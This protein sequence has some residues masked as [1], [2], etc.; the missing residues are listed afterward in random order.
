[1]RRRRTIGS[2]PEDFDDGAV[3]H[4]GATRPPVDVVADRLLGDVSLIELG[5]AIAAV[6]EALGRVDRAVMR[7]REAGHSWQ[8]IAD[9]A[10]I[11]RQSAHERSGRGRSAAS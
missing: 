9:S 1:M 2:R 8:V 3:E 6:D 10:G 5:A 4:D 11:S 7:A